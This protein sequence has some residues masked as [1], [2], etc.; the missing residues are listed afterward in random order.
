MQIRRKL[1]SQR[2]ACDSGEF[3]FQLKEDPCIAPLPH[4]SCLDQLSRARVIES[5]AGV[6]N[7]CKVY[8]LDNEQDFYS[9]A[10]IVDIVISC[11]YTEYSVNKNN[12]N[13]SKRK[14]EMEKKQGK[15]K[16]ELINVIKRTSKL[17]KDPDACH[18]QAEM[19]KSKVIQVGHF[20]GNITQ[21]SFK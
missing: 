17:T 4:E 18:K 19:P 10:F 20:R 2:A 7:V 16:T 14:K 8:T 12:E 3:R 13:K 5:V 11:T 15:T 21:D 6:I 1:L 9:L